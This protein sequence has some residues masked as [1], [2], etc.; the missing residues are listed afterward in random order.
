NKSGTYLGDEVNLNL[1]W[2]VF[3]ELQLIF[4]SGI[5]RASRAYYAINDFNHGKFAKEAFISAEY[6]F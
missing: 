3:S 4:R 2:S 5:F 6:K 1:K